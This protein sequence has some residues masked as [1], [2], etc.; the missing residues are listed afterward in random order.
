MGEIL[1]QLGMQAAGA[2]IGGIGGQIFGAMND[3]RQLRQQQKLTD[4]QIDAD[5]KMTAYNKSAQLQMWKDTS[6]GPQKEQ[7][8][9][10]GINPALMYGMGGGGG[11]TANVSTGNVGGGRAS[12]NTGENVAMAGMGIDMALKQAQIR[13]MESQTNKTN[14]EADVTGGVGKDKIVADT[15]VSNT[16]KKINE[17]NIHVSES[18]LKDQIKQIVQ[19]SQLTMAKKDEI[20]QNVRFGAETF[21]VRSEQVAESVALVIMQQKALS[22]GINVDKAKLGEIAASI[23][24]KWMGLSIEQKKL[25]LQER[26]TIVQE[27]VQENNPSQIKGTLLNMV[28]KGVLEALTGG[29]NGPK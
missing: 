9:K 7:M 27:A 5:Q 21:G 8:E 26:T 25:S 16:V 15:G 28:I 23:A 3:R 6:Y 17:L 11:Q 1:G 12:G 29:E 13:L 22:A 20:N 14:V 10:A 4:M 19:D 18:T 24:Q 2:A